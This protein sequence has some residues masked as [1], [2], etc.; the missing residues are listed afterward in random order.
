MPPLPITAVFAEVPDPRRET[1]NTL[2]DLTDILT[3]ATCAVIGGAESREAI[4][5]YGRTKEGFFRRFLRLDNG[6]PS[7]DTFERVFAKLAPGASARAFGRWMAAACGA[8]GLV[9][10]AID[11]K[12]AR[13][14]RRDTA[15]GCLHVVTAWAAENRLAL[16]TACVP[17]GSNEVAAIPALLRVLDLAG[18]IATIDAAGCRVE[19]ARIIRQQQGH[20]LLT[21]KDNQ[22]T[23]RA[24]V[25]SV[26]E[27]ACEADF[28]DVRCDGHESDEDGHGRHEERYVTVIYDPVGLPAG[29]PDV[30]AVVQVNREREV[31]GERAVTT[32][33][34]I[35]SHPGTAAEFAGRIRGH[36]GIENGLHW[37]LDVVFRGDRSRIRAE[38]AGANLAL[39]RRVA[40][41][42]WWR[43]PGKGSGVT[44]RLKAGWD[45]DY[46][47]QVLQGMTA[48]VVR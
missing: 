22:P 30:A 41:A 47:L 13:A 23:L 9:P 25:E 34:Y 12:S 18:A 32:P 46:L 8:T 40:V 3:V 26:F 4:A 45:D 1:A 42:L 24:A 38:N 14:A 5:E 17:G 29:W 7:P 27:R 36:W 28:E 20:S 16:G 21:V 33:Y 2:H 19:D 44:K 11:G 37:A 48:V 43:A 10:I 31:G 6:I 39:I 15:T 35:A